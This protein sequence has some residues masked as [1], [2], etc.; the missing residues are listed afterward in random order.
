MTELPEPPEFF[1]PAAESPEQEQRVVDSVRQH[2]GEQLGSE[3]S[4]AHF[5]RLEY[6]HDG[7]HHVATVGEPSS[8]NGEPVVMILYEP[9]RSLFH[10]CTTNRGV[11]RG[12]S[13]LVG[14]RSVKTRLAFGA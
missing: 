12:M 1:V 11:L 7:E 5:Y 3:F 6:V 8:V 14:E 9:A 10:V 13:I 4:E 2:L